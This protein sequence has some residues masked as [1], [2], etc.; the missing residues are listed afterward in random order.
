MSHFLDTDVLPRSP[1]D[2]TSCDREP[3]HTPGAIQPQGALLVARRDDLRVTHASGNLEK[4]LGLSATSSLGQSLERILGAVACRRALTL[5]GDNRY[6]PRSVLAIEAPASPFP[7]TMVV[8]AIDGSICVELE[9]ASPGEDEAHIVQRTQAMMHALHAASGQRELCNIVVAKLRELTGYDRV[10]VYRFD[11]EGNGEVIAEDRS[12][13]QE[14]YIGLHYP[15][16]DIPAQARRMYLAQRVRVIADVD[17]DPVTIL[18]DPALASTPPLDMTLC[19]LRSV[20]PAHLEYMRNMGS[21]ASLGISLIPATSLWGLLVCH[22]RSPLVISASVR[23]QCDLIGQLLSLLLGSLGEMEAYAEQLRRQRSLQEV[24][25][26]LSESDKVTEALR[27]S[28]ETLLSLLESSGAIV[29]LGGR[30]VTLGVTP[31]VEAAQRVMTA[32][33]A[34]SDGRLVAVDELREFVPEWATECEAASGALYLPLPSNPDDAIIWFRPET[35]KVVTWGGN[36]AKPTLLDPDSGRLS[37]RR[38]FAAWRERIAGHS[39]PWQEADRAVAGDLR[40]AITLAIARQSEAELAKQRYY[41]PLTGL[42]NRRM[43]Q[44]HLADRQAMSSAALLYV[45]LDRFKAIN[46]TK[47]HAAGDAML[48]QVAQRL[49]RTVRNNDLVARVGG[50]EFVVFCDDLTTIEAEQLAE[51]IRCTLKAPFTVGGRSFYAGAS[52]G[53]AHTDTTRINDLFA[54]GDTAMYVAKRQGGSRATTFAAPLRAEACR[55]LELEQGLHEALLDQKQLYL[56]YQ[57]VFRVA[58]RQLIGFEALA[59]WTHPLFGRIPPGHFI[60]IAEKTDLIQPIGAWALREAIAQIRCWQTHAPDRTF[61]VAVNVSPLQLQDP[62]FDEDLA[63]LLAEAGVPGSAICLEVTE[64]TFLD[65]EASDVL[66][67][68][69]R[70][71]LRVAIDDFGVGFS[72]LSYLR[73]IPA[74]IVKLDRSFLEGVD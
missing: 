49:T 41:D 37:P 43:F 61:F 14:P 57:P 33:N 60:P 5:L 67:A 22:H 24:V 4:Y 39:T 58:D 25:A 55:A 15:A 3:I 2:L 72:S 74:D 59:R 27:S 17:Y 44:E 31:E 26:R 46:D 64:G 9:A 38:S 68:V 73:R 29:R 32:L 21:A 10:L 48:V 40:R 52:I 36:P 62:A 56:D 50:D 65:G 71:G 45:D 51:R 70:L 12:E 54:A 23:A 66:A 11:R 35:V 19:Q 47:G 34:A 69:R 42:P 28:G 63:G 7:L 30:M 13:G 16:S 1:I 53:V 6:I 20:S 8:H 18:T